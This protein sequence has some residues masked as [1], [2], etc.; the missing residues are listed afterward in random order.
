[1]TPEQLA[2]E[3]IDRQLDACGWIVQNRKEMN[4]YAGPG[5][6]VRDAGQTE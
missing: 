1:M 6:A 3:A 4:I 5:V 2:R